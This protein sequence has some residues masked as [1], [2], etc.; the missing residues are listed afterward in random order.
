MH[1]ASLQPSIS[2]LVSPPQTQAPSLRFR[3]SS[4]PLPILPNIF[5]AAWW[6]CLPPP[7]D[8]DCQLLLP[9][10]QLSKRVC[11]LSHPA[12]QNWDSTINTGC[13]GNTGVCQ[14]RNSYPRSDDSHRYSASALIQSVHSLHSPVCAQVEDVQLPAMQKQTIELKV[15]NHFCL[16][17]LK[18]LKL[19]QI[20]TKAPA[21]RFILSTLDNTQSALTLSCVSRIEELSQG[22]QQHPSTVLPLVYIILQSFH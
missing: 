10:C 9:A 13:K 21:L 18:C 19:R 3:G 4:Q 20:N 1:H 2:H 5:H 6:D 8:V 7:A 11:A 14:T 17:S 15:T 16:K 22:Q 12:F